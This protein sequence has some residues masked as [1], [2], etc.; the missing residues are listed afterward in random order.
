[1]PETLSLER[2]YPNPFNPITTISFALPEEYKVI[3]EVY[4][5]NFRIINTITDSIMKEGYRSVV[6]NA[7]SLSSGVY[8]IRMQ[9]GDYRSIQKLMLVK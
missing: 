2:V 3:L 6:W 9:A 8:F 7:E 1:M 5:V 4:N